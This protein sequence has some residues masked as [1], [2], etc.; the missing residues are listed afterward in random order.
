M[1]VCTLSIKKKKLLKK[2]KQ[3]KS[4]THQIKK[5]TRQSQTFFC[6][7]LVTNNLNI[8]KIL[9]IRNSKFY[10]IIC[11]TSLSLK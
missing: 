3:S 10:T 4:V 7:V 2:K 1:N 6:H 8:C 11:Q 5:K 9:T